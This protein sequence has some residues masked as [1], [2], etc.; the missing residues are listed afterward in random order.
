LKCPDTFVRRRH[1][2]LRAVVSFSLCQPYIQ[3]C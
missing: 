3:A 1:L 2:S